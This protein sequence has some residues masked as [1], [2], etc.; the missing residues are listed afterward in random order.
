VTS[1]IRGDITPELMT[2]HQ[3]ALANSDE[4]LKNWNGNTRMMWADL[5]RGLLN[6]RPSRLTVLPSPY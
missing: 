6:D 2:Q 4:T 3:S 5:H 1:K